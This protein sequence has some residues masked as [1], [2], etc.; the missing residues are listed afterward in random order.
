MISAT[1]IMLEDLELA[2]EEGP[3]E[4]VNSNLQ[5]EATLG[6]LL[7]RGRDRSATWR[8]FQRATIRCA[9]AAVRPRWR[10]HPDVDAGRRS[11]H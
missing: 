11:G 10:Q 8:K 4:G 9:A 5:L 3:L 7:L 1:A 6:L 2:V